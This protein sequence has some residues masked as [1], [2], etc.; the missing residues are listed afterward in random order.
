MWDTRRERIADT[1]S[2]F[3][4]KVT[5]PLATS[6][7]LILA[8]LADIIQALRNPTPHNSLLPL[9]TQ[10]HNMLT[11]LATVLTGLTTKPQPAPANMPPAL[12]R[13]PPG[14]PPLRVPTTGTTPL[15]INF[16]PQEQPAA[17]PQPTTGP[18]LIPADDTPLDSSPPPT[19][20][21]PLPPPTTPVTYDNSTGTKGRRKRRQTRQAARPKAVQAP[22]APIPFA[23][24]TAEAAIA[25]TNCL[26]PSLH[27]ALHGNAFNPDTGK[28]AEYPELSQCSDGP[29]WRESNA[30]E[31]GRLAQG[32]KGIKG[33]NTIFF[34]RRKAIPKGRKPTYLRIVSAYHPEKDNPHRIRWTCGG[35]RMDYPGATSTKTADLS[36]VKCHLN[37][38]ISTPHARY[39][40]GD[41][42]DFYLGT[43][44]KHY[45]YMRI[46][47][48]YIPDQIMDQYELWDL[49][50]NDFVYVEIRRGMYGLPQA[51]RLANDALCAFLAPH[52]YKPV[53]IT[54]GLWRHQTRDITF[55]LVVDDFGI[56]YNTRA[57]VDH[58]LN[59]LKQKYV[60]KEDWKGTRYCRLTMEWDYPARAVTISMPGYIERVLK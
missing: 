5:L 41:L 7:D 14:E 37:S 40:T 27:Y 43:P 8:A 9:T 39:M 12:L 54:P 47:V 13:V 52:G 3:P 45:E 49:V 16:E 21:L 23:A 51:G 30:E 34:I 55:T 56:K 46:P 38:V 31:I 33:T 1:L 28:I 20:P 4:S 18:T 25:Y 6:N 58:L 19:A 42:K 60:V 57:D 11:T 24:C 15:R 2:W 59:T 22:T 29:I 44:M 48:K 35:D 26:D 17:P 10:H 50:E 53:P 36:T 32:Y